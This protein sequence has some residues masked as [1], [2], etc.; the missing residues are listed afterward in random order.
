MHSF[1]CTFASPFRGGQ[2]AYKAELPFKEVM[3]TPLKS[4]MFFHA[5]VHD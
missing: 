3:M 2:K 4:V 5:Y 1:L